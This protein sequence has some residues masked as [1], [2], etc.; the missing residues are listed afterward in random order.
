V[1]IVN[2]CKHKGEGDRNRAPPGWWLGHGGEDTP[3]EPESLG[4]DDEEEE[5]DGKKGK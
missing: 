4:G 5:K 2:E 1:S 3:S